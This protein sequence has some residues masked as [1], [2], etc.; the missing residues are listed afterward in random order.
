MNINLEVLEY[1]ALPLRG[2]D[3]TYFRDYGNMTFLSCL[4]SVQKNSS[5]MMRVSE[6]VKGLPLVTERK[7]LKRGPSV[8][9]SFGD[10]IKNWTRV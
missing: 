10:A 6:S 1:E 9:V 7:G 3:C 5:E 8:N 2:S 4:L